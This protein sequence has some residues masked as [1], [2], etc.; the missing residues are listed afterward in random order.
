MS[1][2]EAQVAQLVVLVGVALAVALVARRVQLPYTLALVVVGLLLGVT[3]V[4][5]DLQLDPAVVLLI[6]LPVLL[7]EGALNVNLGLLRAYAPMIL[8]LAVPGLCLSLGVVALTLHLATGMDWLPALLVGAIV[9]PTDPV[10]VLALLRQ[11]GMAAGARTII[12]GESLLNDGVGAAAFVTVLGILAAE[13]GVSHA[14]V[15]PALVTLQ[16]AWLLVGGPLIGVAL[17]LIA[18][19]LMRRVSDHLIETTITFFLAYGAYLAGELLHTSGLLAVVFAGLSLSGAMRMHRTALTDGAIGEI[20]EFAGY[21]ANSLLFLVL[22]VQIGATNVVNALPAIAWGVVGV[23]AGRAIML[24]VFAPLVNLLIA[25][26]RFARWRVMP[27]GWTPLLLFSG[28]RGALSLA[29]VLSLPPS[30]PHLATIE[31]IV[32]GV[33]LVTLLGQ[34]IGLRVI[35]PRLHT[36]AE[37]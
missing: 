9:S 6:F 37:S 13:T 29:L 32:Y 5:P 34:G 30:L 28:L 19:R 36:P 22:G 10:A 23:I 8:A 16:A 26:F 14:S 15:M 33:V 2:L 1:D 35:L 21:L 20:W 31:G 3:H 25:R 18:T 4:L 17:G 11:L 12:E 27:T 24:A 7:F